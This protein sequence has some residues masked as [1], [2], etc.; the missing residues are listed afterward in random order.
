MINN[1]KEII[2]HSMAFIEDD[3]TELWVIA[4]KVQ[5]RNP[6]LNFEELIQATN[7]VVRELVV[8][9]NVQVLDENTQLPLNL[10]VNEIL[11]LVEKK[12]HQLKRIPNIGD[13][14]WFTI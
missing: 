14:I 3:F 11:E 1:L 13:G 8:K 7:D 12:F 10:S 2:S 5:E 4:T 9:N 6:T